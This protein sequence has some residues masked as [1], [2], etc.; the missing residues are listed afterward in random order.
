MTTNNFF[1]FSGMK[2]TTRY[3]AKKP[4][5]Y[6]LVYPEMAETLVSVWNTSFAKFHDEIRFSLGNI[7]TII[8]DNGMM[9]MRLNPSMK[10]VNTNAACVRI[11][12][13]AGI[14]KE[15]DVYTQVSKALGKKVSIEQLRAVLENLSKPKDISEAFTVFADRW[16]LH[17]YNDTLSVSSDKVDESI[18]SVIAEFVEENYRYVTGLFNYDFQLR[19]YLCNE[20][21]TKGESTTEARNSIIH[22]LDIDR[23]GDTT[24]SVFELNEIYMKS[25][26]FMR[27]VMI[28]CTGYH[29]PSVTG[30]LLARMFQPEIIVSSM[31]QVLKT[32]LTIDEAMAYLKHRGNDVLMENLQNA[33]GLR[34]IFDEKFDFSDKTPQEAFKSIIEFLFNNRNSLTEEGLTVYNFL[35]LH[36]GPM[37]KFT[38]VYERKVKNGLETIVTYDDFFQDQL[39]KFG[40]LMME[41]RALPA[42][43]KAFLV[44]SMYG[45]G[46]RRT[47]TKMYGCRELSAE[48]LEELDNAFDEAYEV[49]NRDGSLDELMHQER[50]RAKADNKLQIV[51][52]DAIRDAGGDETN[53]DTFI[54]NGEVD[55]TWEAILSLEGLA[56]IR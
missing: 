29:N 49:Y 16:I 51:S 31:E 40:Q 3:G 56:A 50:Q 11:L 21:H 7:V 24:K 13:N 47:N 52:L 39:N 55:P 48:I 12:Y 43:M 37:L 19:G 22:G 26:E 10:W 34:E 5:Y 1:D 44:D 23:N 8:K 42:T 9:K 27:Q 20:H 17:E 36:I 30:L 18:V 46:K 2:L 28:D 4:M 32:S 45:A 41:P 35:K 15:S 6:A 33:I 54:D 53:W 38:G 14:L 25:E